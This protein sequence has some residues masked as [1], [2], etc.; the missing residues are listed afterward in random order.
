MSKYSLLSAL[1]H[2]LEQAILAQDIELAHQIE[3]K[4]LC[5]LKSIIDAGNI[6]ED[7]VSVAATEL[8]RENKLR[9][10]VENEKYKLEQQ[11]KNL[12]SAEKVSNIY[13]A[14]SR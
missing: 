12:L 9:S 5:I 1:S 10:L 13:K 11:I 8:E 14:N 7:I 3:D 2:Q 6:S 4:R